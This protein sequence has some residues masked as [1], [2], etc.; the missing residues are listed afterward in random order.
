M[1]R[2]IPPSSCRAGRCEGDGGAALGATALGGPSGAHTDPQ[3][4]GAL[5]RERSPS[6]Q[7]PRSRLLCA[8]D[9]GE[10]EPAGK[11]LPSRSPRGSAASGT[12]LHSLCRRGMSS[13][14]GSASG[15]AGIGM[16]WP[17]ALLSQRTRSSRA[18]P[19]F[20]QPAKKGRK[21]SCRHEPFPGSPLRSRGIPRAGRDAGSLSNT[22]SKGKAQGSQGSSEQGGL[23]K[24]M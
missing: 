12:C 10:L 1:L 18:Q 7:G 21:A 16:R 23:G 9:A 19:G 22:F 2:H 24:K 8:V 3:W 13:H 5:P 14:P 15:V 20:A 4:R 17:V 6:Q 11:K